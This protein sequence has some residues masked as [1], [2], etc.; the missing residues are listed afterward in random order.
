MPAFDE[1]FNNTIN[2]SISDNDIIIKTNKTSIVSILHFNDCYNIESRI[3]EPS[4]GAARM[5]TAFNSYRDCDPLVLFSG[6]II[7]P[8]IMSTFTKGEQMIP[9]LNALGINCAVFGNHEFDFGVDYLN[10]FMQRTNFPWLMSNVYNPKTNRPINN[11]NIWHIIDRN[12]KRFGI[13]GLVEEQWL[14][15]ALPEGYVYRDFVSEGRKLAQRLK[16][17]E[18]VDFV[19]ALTHMRWPNDCL[20]AENVSEI[21]LILGGHDHDYQIRTINNKLCVKSGTDFRQFSKIDIKFTDND[22]KYDIDCNEINVN[23]YDFKEDEDIKHE[24][25]PYS[26]IVES[27]MDNVLCEMRVDLDG[28]F[29][30]IRNRETNLGNFISDICLISTGADVVLLNS[31]MFRSDQIHS[32]GD[33]KFRDLVRILPMMDELVV[34]NITGHQ[35]LTALECSLCRWPILDGSFAQISRIRFEFD[36]H[37]PI[38]K[39]IDINTIKIGRKNLDL[40]RHYR[41]VTEEFLHKGK[42]GY[43]VLKECEVLIPKEHCLDIFT[44]VKNYLESV[45]QLRA[46]PEANSKTLVCSGGTKTLAIDKKEYID[47]DIELRKLEPKCDGRITNLGQI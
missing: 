30:S 42:D 22:F 20:L 36:S 33:F 11:A 7:S 12:D 10:S 25:Q 32:K 9:V 18:S 28:K 44:L 38:G 47:L 16:N 34:L 21:D 31:G 27:Q 45:K 13:I 43:Y 5:V 1:T 15:D 39:R 8:S 19:I 14:I 17:M 3:D 41:L 29:A 4:G 35:L 23:S 46:D 37:K 24:L 6:D 2:K 40:K 26:L